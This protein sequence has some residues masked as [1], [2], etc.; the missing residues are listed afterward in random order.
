MISTYYGLCCIIAALFAWA[1]WLNLFGPKFIAEE[2]RNWNY[3]DS[4]RIG[5]GIGEWI[6][7]AMLFGQFMPRLA[8]LG[9]ISI[10][11]AVVFTL[12]R[13]GLFMRLETPAI[14]LALLAI[15]LPLSPALGMFGL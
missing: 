8:I 5:V 7:A 1:G 12:A 11:L 4:L 2:F 10:M 14:V 15:T 6:L 9:A 13:H 3:P